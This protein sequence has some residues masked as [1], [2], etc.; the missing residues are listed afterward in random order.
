[1]RVAAVIP[2]R[3]GSQRLPGKNRADIGGK[4][5]WRHSLEHALASS[6]RPVVVSTDD[7][8]I[9]EQCTHPATITVLQ[10]KFPQTYNVMQQVLAHA[11]EQLWMRGIDPEAYCLLQPTSPLRLVED[12]QAC[13]DAVSNSPSFDAAVSV[14]EG[15]DDIAFEMRFAGRLERLPKIVVPNGAVYVVRTKVLRD[16]GSW[17]G[18]HT[19][20]HVMPKER[21]VDVD[22]AVDLEVARV[23]WEKLYGSG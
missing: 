2:A 16:G 8:D 11:D 21:S 9:I 14:T 13:V 3:K 4:E 7:E 20:G 23:T 5:M 6:C 18:D 12:V 19:Y 15:A 17:Y 1:M 10:P 22:T